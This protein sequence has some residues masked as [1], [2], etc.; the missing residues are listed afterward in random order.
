LKIKTRAFYEKLGKKEKKMKNK[1]ILLGLLAIMLVFGIMVTG[2][3]GGGGG[4]SPTPEPEVAKNLKITGIKGIGTK[5]VDVYLMDSDSNI[6]AGGTS[7]TKATVIISLKKL[8]VTVTGGKTSYAFTSDNWTGKGDFGILLF[9]TIGSSYIFGETP[10]HVS[11]DWIKFQNE[12]TTV[13]WNDFIDFDW[14][15][16]KPNIRY[17]FSVK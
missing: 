15:D 2:C 7:E 10:T 11:K 3:G 8:K 12:T 16:S 4:G 9:E 5:Y 13:P 17:N 14:S 6:I 1:K